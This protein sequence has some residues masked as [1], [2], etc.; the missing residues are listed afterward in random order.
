MF[1]INKNLKIFLI[2]LTAFLFLFFTKGKY[3]EFSKSKSIKSCMSAQKKILKDKPIEE[4][5]VFC[6]EEINKNI[7]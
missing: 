6:E 7:K 5:K 1:K 3:G 2:I 4:I